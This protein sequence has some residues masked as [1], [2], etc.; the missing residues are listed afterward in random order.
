[1]N[2]I[3]HTT[4]SGRLIR[5]C[6]VRYAPAGTAVASF[7]IAVN[8]RFQDKAGQ[9]QEEA[10]FINCVAFGRMAEQLTPCGKGAPVLVTGRLNTETWFKN[11]ANHSRLVLVC[12][13]VLPIQPL[14]KSTGDV[15]KQEA[16]PGSEQVQNET[17]H[18]I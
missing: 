3:N 12:E 2:D 14:P 9:W 13:T 10:A 5:D 8:R 4:A 11:N 16:L 17:D 1:M 15:E 6:E 7:A 18:G